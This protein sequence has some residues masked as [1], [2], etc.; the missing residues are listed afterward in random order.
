MS[1]PCPGSS[2]IHHRLSP[3]SASRLGI[4]LRCADNEATLCTY[5]QYS[6]VQWLQW[7]RSSTGL[8]SPRELVGQPKRIMASAIP[9]PTPPPPQDLG[10]HVAAG[11]GGATSVPRDPE[12][13]YWP[14]HWLGAGAASCGEGVCALQAWG[15]LLSALALSLACDAPLACLRGGPVPPEAPGALR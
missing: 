5:A 7:L 15:K 3:D 12:V 10:E 8:P 6:T 11:C 9:Y 13:S 14:T 2:A 1:N 4:Q